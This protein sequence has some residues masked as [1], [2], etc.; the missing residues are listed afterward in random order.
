MAYSLLA[1]PG[2]TAAPPHYEPTRIEKS[3]VV[4]YDVQREA[5][6]KKE[7]YRKRVTL[8]KQAVAE[9][10]PRGPTSGFN[11]AQ[12]RSRA[13]PASTLGGG[14][15]IPTLCF[16]GAGAWAV[17][18]FAPWLAG[19]INARHNPWSMAPAPSSRGLM[20]DEGLVSEFLAAFRPPPRAQPA[21][22]EEAEVNLVAPAL[23]PREQPD[24]GSMDEFYSAASGHLIEIRRLLEE[25]A[26]PQAKRS[27]R[28]ILLD[29]HDRLQSLRVLP[30]CPELRPLWQMAY[31]LELLTRQLTER[32]ND[33]TPSTIRSL[34]QGVDA[35]VDLCKPGVDRSLFSE[36]PLRFLAVDDEAISRLA[37][38]FSLKRILS[39]PDVARDGPEGLALATERTYDVIFLDVRMPGVDGFELCSR[40]HELAANRETPVVFVT[41]LN[42]FDTRAKSVLS[43]GNDLLGKPFLTFEVAVRALTL[44]ARRRVRGRGSP[45]RTPLPWA[46][47]T[48]PPDLVL[49]A[50]PDLRGE[51]RPVA[52]NLFQAPRPLPVPPREAAHEPAVAGP[53]RGTADTFLAHAR[54]QAQHLRELAELIELA[55]E[56]F[57]KEEMLSDLFL[58]A[59]SLRLCAKEAGHHTIL[60]I[61][62][63]LETLLK[64]L[65]GDPTQASLSSPRA[66]IAAASLIEGLCAA[67]ASA[68]TVLAAPVRA[69]AVDDDPIAL[70][71]ITQVLQLKF[72]KP[73]TA[74]DGNSALAL[75]AERPCDVIFL[76]LQMPDVDGFA[77]CSSIRNAEGPNRHT[78]VVFVTSHD[79]PALREQARICGGDDF[80]TKPFLCSELTLRALTFAV[81]GRLQHADQAGKGT[82]NAERRP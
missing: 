19:I 74:S 31:A 46:A 24:V 36:P 8:P 80:I 45:A 47:G 14:E 69:L 73:A 17:F 39:E 25:I 65:L 3:G 18:R 23:P 34:F 59:H 67:P 58:K 5:E 52:A 78:P 77:V 20:A 30:E 54:A 26:C 4:R 13:V 15:M 11:P 27:R 21:A 38:S 16:L 44:V 75:A 12:S 66:I 68:D 1:G 51:A 10:W 42:D 71:A 41:V 60:E 61:S 37:L 63:L 9:G 29:I 62:T 72:P 6:A 64:K 81:R 70:R 57:I 50:A 76:D 48:H 40:L 82:Q 43:G 33:I 22:T 32:T 7:Q 49:P 28:N 35:L 56:Q 53:P 55:A 2:P 79:D